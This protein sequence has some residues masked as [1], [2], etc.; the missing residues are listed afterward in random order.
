MPTVLVDLLSYTGT[1]GGMETYA[2][3]LYRAIAATDSDLTFVGLAS[4][5]GYALDQSWFPGKVINSG[6]SGESRFIWAFGELLMVTRWAKK[7]GADLIH[8]PAT[9]G[10]MRRSVP[11]VVTMHDMLY[12]SH[13]ELMS[14]GLYTAPVKWMEQRAAR[15]ATR[16]VTISNVSRDEILRFLKV[17][18]ARLDVIPLA[19]AASPA[20]DRTLHDPSSQGLLLATGNRRPHKNWEGLIRALSIVDAAIRPRL[21]I[22]G[23]HG[24][25]PLRP[26]VEELKLE[27]W[28]EL[29][30]WVS[31]EELDGLYSTATALVIPSFC[32]GFSLPALEAM[33]A[34]VPTLISGI[35]VHRE[36]AGD[37][38]LYFD[39]TD[40]ASIARA[41]TTA[42]TDPAQMSALVERGYARA[43]QFSWATTAAKTLESFRKA[44]GTSASRLPVPPQ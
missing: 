23:S 39:P 34:G 40:P 5:E 16:I 35:A 28:V 32:E 33:M 37:A 26:L 41:I 21:V 11:S 18:P 6:I 4:T 30:S 13:P 42:V 27:R 1:K 10:T 8:S 7:I 44:L 3:E 9:L 17:D 36:V 2:R 22:T 25:D 31:K 12:W 20:A 14:T 29:K 43:H 15:A 19:G 24:E 38:A